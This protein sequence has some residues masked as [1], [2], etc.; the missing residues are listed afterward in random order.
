ML[1]LNPTSLKL[2]V[3]VV[4]EGT[5]AGAAES[6]HIAA[7]AVSKRLSEIEATL[8]VALL[9]RTNKGVEPT[10]AGSALLTL[11]RRA[12][13]ELEQI[14]VQMQSYA[15]GVSGVVRVSASMSAITQ[16]LPAD[17]KSFLTA[18]PGVQLHLEEKLSSAAAKAVAENSADIGIFTDTPHGA[19]V[20]TFQ[21]HTDRLVLCVPKGH[22]FAAKTEL[23]FAQTLDEDIVGMHSGSAIGLQLSR[24]ASLAQR[25]FNLRIQVT[26][27]DA[28][29]M[30]ISCGLGIGVLPKAVARRNA[31]KLDI[32]LVNL[33]D[34]WAHREFKICVRASETLPVAVRLLVEHLKESARLAAT[35][36]V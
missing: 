29:C 34:A 10:A 17:I 13:H 12:L 33:S 36:E 25:M 1:R 26:S 30:M 5:I 16:F 22:R 35:H 3:R 23:S 28:L 4:E 11:A 2:F 31:A 18:Y 20:E 27:F 14:P 8:G 9:M 32:A 21:Y 7:A 15:S 24:A 6:E 19:Q